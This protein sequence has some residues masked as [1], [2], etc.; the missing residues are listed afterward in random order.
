MKQDAIYVDLILPVPLR[1]LFTYAVSEEMKLHVE[2]GKRVVVNFGKKKIYTALIKRVHSEKPV[3]ETKEILSVLDKVPIIS[4]NQLMFWNWMAEYYMCSLGEIYKAA[5]P[6]GLKLE[7]ETNIVLNSEANGEDI[8]EKEELIIG[9]L[10]DGKA[11]II[12]QIEQAAGFNV[13]PTI[14]KLVE[15]NIISAEERLKK[16]YSKKYEDF[17]GINMKLKDESFLNSII[18]SLSKAPKQKELLSEFI[19]LTHFGSDKFEGL[20]SADEF[21]KSDILKHTGAKQS[22]LTE[23]VKKEYLIQTKKEV[24]RIYRD[25]DLIEGKKDLNTYQLKALKSVQKGFLEKD[26][27]LLHGVTSSGKTEIYIHLISEQLKAGKQ[28][29]YLLPEIALTSQITTRL[30]KIFGNELAVYHSKFNDNE[31]VEVWKGMEEKKYKLILGVRSSVFLPFENL[32]LIIV[33]EEHENTYKQYNPAPR[34][35]ARDA[36]IVS[37]KLYG[38]KVLLGTATPSIESYYN[39]KSGKYVLVELFQRYKEIQLPEI[40]IVNT[41]DARKQH[42]MKSMF[43]VQMLN[44]VSEALAQNEQIILF[45][46]RRGFSP[47]IECSSCGYIPKCEHCDVSLTYHKINKQLICH[48]C[49]YSLQ[50]QKMCKSCQKLTMET[51]GFGTQK[52]ED[53]LKILFPDVKIARMD[54]DSTIRKKAFYN[55]ISDF[56]TGKTNILIGTQMISKGLD[57]ENVSLVGILNADNMLNFPDFRAFERSFQLMTQVSGRSGRKNKQGKVIIQTSESKHPIILNVKENNYK[58]M[59]ISQLSQRKQFKYPPFY[60]LIQISIKHKNKEIV[61]MASEQL[62]SE[63][64]SRFG[65]RVLGPEYPIIARIKNWYIKTILI[66]IERN[67]SHTKVKEIINIKIF[68]IKSKDNFKS[69]IFSTDVDL[70]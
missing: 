26:V 62:A 32:G 13:M 40:E 44:A 10:K 57:F 12:S 9:I 38:A 53:E 29:L 42:K 67:V 35:N 4:E 43:S 25:I 3:Y 23:L 18:E 17:I 1:Q 24:S 59:F 68:Q 7:S 2:I 60:R 41:R 6:S 69:V 37:A 49:G 20:K 63:L 65:N 27:V 11:H 31:R 47:Y 21:L 45:Q 70:M 28:V 30:E 16:K 39:A 22:H 8:N 14:K 36:S 5:L 34:Y 58:E 54:F 64:R 15:K 46:N 55:I 66:K 48:Y 52:I 61:D 50:A 19:Y 33:D 56:E 51:K